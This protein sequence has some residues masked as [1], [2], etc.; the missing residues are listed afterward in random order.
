MP[1]ASI[2]Y[3]W[4]VPTDSERM[5][6]RWTAPCTKVH[7]T[8]SRR[9]ELNFILCSSLHRS[10]Q[11]RGSQCGSGGCAIWCS[12]SIAS[13]DITSAS[14]HAGVGFSDSDISGRRQQCVTALLQVCLANTPRRCHVLHKALH[15]DSVVL[16]GTR[17]AFTLA[18]AVCKLVFTC[19]LTAGAHASLRP[20]CLKAGLSRPR[21]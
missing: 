4:V 12:S 21:G 20:L 1:A 9:M 15:K 11:G 10:V 5:R 13:Q 8:P 7:F 6:R 16:L 19:L 14:A 17:A 2:K 18:A 3:V